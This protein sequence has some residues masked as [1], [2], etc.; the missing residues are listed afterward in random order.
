MERRVM[1]LVT[2]RIHGFRGQAV[3]S[4]GGAN[5]RSEDTNSPLFPN[6]SKTRSRV[7]AE[8]SQFPGLF[9]GRGSGG[10]LDQ[11]RH[12]LDIV[13]RGEPNENAYWC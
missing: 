9:R 12:G 6:T 7:H 8:R 4:S 10:W 2:R 1:T 3:G 5:S 13:E 11:A